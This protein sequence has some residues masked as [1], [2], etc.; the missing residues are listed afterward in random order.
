M[1]PLNSR[2]HTSAAAVSVFALVAGL[3]GCAETNQTELTGSAGPAFV[4]PAELSNQGMPDFLKPPHSRVTDPAA[5]Q[6][7]ATGYRYAQGQ[8]DSSTFYGIYSYVDD[9]WSYISTSIWDNSSNS[10]SNGMDI[11]AAGDTWLQSGSY[12]IDATGVAFGDYATSYVGA[13]GIGTQYLTDFESSASRAHY[14]S[15]IDHSNTAASPD[16]LYVSDWESNFSSSSQSCTRDDASFWSCDYS[17]NYEP[18]V[19]EDGVI[20]DVLYTSTQ[21]CDDSLTAVT[22]DYEYVDEMVW[23]YLT[24]AY[25]DHAKMNC[26]QDDGTA[27]EFTYIYSD[28]SGG[29]YDEGMQPVAAPTCG[30]SQGGNDL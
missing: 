26:V 8:F 15:T 2:I 9:E 25:S 7:I 20:V 29:W 17:Y 5:L 21:S 23:N 19:D 10:M 22:P 1:K 4:Q 30:W 27:R 6:K 18:H 13:D 16:C 3:Y 11:S 14:L 12:F 28:G 24:G